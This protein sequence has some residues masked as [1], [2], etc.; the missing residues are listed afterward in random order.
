MPKWEQKYSKVNEKKL[1]LHNQPLLLDITQYDSSSGGPVWSYK[2]YTI[3]L[4]IKCCYKSINNPTYAFT[5]IT[6]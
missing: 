2:N 3:L 1:S 4:D 6:F 5:S